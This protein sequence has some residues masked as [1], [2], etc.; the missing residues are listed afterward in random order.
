MGMI[1][2]TDDT[3]EILQLVNTRFNRENFHALIWD[4]NHSGTNWAN[5]FQNMGSTATY[6]YAN[7]AAPLGL[8]FDAAAAT[9]TIRSKRWQKFLNYLD[10]QNSGT[11]TT[12][13]AALIGAALV[14]SVNNTYHA[15]E[16]FAVPSASM[17]LSTSMYQINGEQSMAITIYTVPVDQM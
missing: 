10:S 4:Q 7:V 3:S 5:L 15:V 17:S 12:K 9:R 16:F 14:T 6:T 13:C 2:N 11:T 1:F 8:D